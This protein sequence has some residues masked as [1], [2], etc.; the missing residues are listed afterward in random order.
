MANMLVLK[1][2]QIFILVDVFRGMPLC[3]NLVVNNK[4][5]RVFIEVRQEKL[6]QVYINLY[7]HFLAFA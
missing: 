3:E 5:N 2:H 4:D 1:E 6:I 7:N